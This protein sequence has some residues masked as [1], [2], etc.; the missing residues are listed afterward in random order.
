MTTTVREAFE[1]H[2]E[3]FNSHD[4]DRFASTLADDVVFQA[5]G[6]II[7]EG[8]SACAQFYGGWMGAFPDAHVEIHD[9][10]IAG[11]VAVEE[12]TFTGTHQGVLR[13]PDGDVPSTGRPVT[14]DYIQVLRYHDGRYISFN[15]MYDQ[16]SLLEQL[17]LIPA[18]EPAR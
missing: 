1:Q 16:L 6:G 14:V 10:H 7:G 18:Q 15:L 17:G 2:T 5:P 12:G 3:A 9:L 13:A 8:K 4:I 11:D